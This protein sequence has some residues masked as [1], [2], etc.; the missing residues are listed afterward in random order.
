MKIE[1]RNFVLQ[2]GQT[3]KDRW[4]VIRMRPLLM[5][6]LPKMREKYG[7]IPIGTVIGTTDDELAYDMKLDHA[8]SKIVAYLLA[9]NEDTTDLKG[10]IAEYKRLKSEL[11]AVIP[12]MG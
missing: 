5:S 10:F 11:E 3:A 7:D 9:D 8:I 12:D 4:D 2:P 1:Y 6:N